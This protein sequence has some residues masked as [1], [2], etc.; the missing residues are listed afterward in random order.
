MCSIIMFT[1]YGKGYEGQIFPS[2][3]FSFK[4]YNNASKQLLFFCWKL[5]GPRLPIIDTKHN[6]ENVNEH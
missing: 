1:G 3:A 5:T 4:L 2:V 6:N